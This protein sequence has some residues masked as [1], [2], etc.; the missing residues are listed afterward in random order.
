MKLPLPLKARREP[1]CVPDRS[2]SWL[3]EGPGLQ[4][5]LQAAAAERFP[6]VWVPI[7]Q[8]HKKSVAG[9]R[10][11]ARCL[12]CSS[13]VLGIKQLSLP[14]HNHWLLGFLCYPLKL[15]ATAAEISIFRPI[16]FLMINSGNILIVCNYQN[17]VICLKLLSNAVLIWH[18]VA[19][20]ALSS[21]SSFVSDSD[22]CKGSMYSYGFHQGFDSSETGDWGGNA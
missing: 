5:A 13:S 6:T 15:W 20:L 2:P 3:S 4:S 14:M 7:P 21:K 9:L 22:C 10:K 19:S 11:Q 8:R 1:W 12:S 17:T 16:F 18:C